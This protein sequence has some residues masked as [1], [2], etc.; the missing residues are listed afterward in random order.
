MGGINGTGLEDGMGCR[1]G[2]NAHERPGRACCK[3]CN[4]LQPGE[5]ICPSSRLPAPSPS[6][7]VLFRCC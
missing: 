1:L 7:E 5:E 4:R 6:R 3:Q 2:F